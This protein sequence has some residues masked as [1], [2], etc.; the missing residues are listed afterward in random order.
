MMMMMMTMVQMAPSRTT[1]NSAAGIM[2]S[3]IRCPF[4]EASTSAATAQSASQSSAPGAKQQTA[5]SAVDLSV[6]QSSEKDAV[7]RQFRNKKRWLLV[8]CVVC[9]GSDLAATALV[10]CNSNG[11]FDLLYW[12]E[13]MRVTHRRAF[14]VSESF[15]QSVRQ[16]KCL[17]S[18]NA[19]INWVICSWLFSPIPTATLPPSLFMAPADDLQPLASARGFG[20][21]TVTYVCAGLIVWSAPS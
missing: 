5:T 8:H 18:T 12:L 15:T 9:S 10:L 13:F 17:L 20:P 19:Q 16:S 4:K 2:G 11:Q 14:W 1:L 21:S 7:W 3:V 6:Q